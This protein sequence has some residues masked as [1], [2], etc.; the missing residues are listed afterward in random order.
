MSAP[1][2]PL[3]VGITTDVGAVAD[4]FKQ[5]TVLAGQIQA[6]LNSPLMVD[7]KVRQEKQDRLDAI[8]RAIAD[9][10]LTAIRKLSSP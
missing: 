10:D 8:N 9:G 2:S 3:D 7:A 5:G 6:E 1:P 4:A